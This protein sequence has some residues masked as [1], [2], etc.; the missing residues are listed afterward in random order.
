MT[1]RT[2]PS[3]LAQIFDAEF[4]DAESSALE[5]LGPRYNV[6]PT[7]PI[8]VVVQ[9]RRWSA[10]RVASLGARAFVVQV[11]RLG[12]SGLHQC[13]CRNACDKFGLQELIPAPSLRHPGRRLL[14]V[15]PRRDSE[16]AVPDSHS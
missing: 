10:D 13:A 4:G 16:M 5:E 3:E 15:A 6:A 12:W 1:M 9:R 11:G 14:R 2:N 7:Q 8:P